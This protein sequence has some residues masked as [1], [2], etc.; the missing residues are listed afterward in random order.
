MARKLK[1]IQDSV[2][3]A[4]TTTFSFRN[5]TRSIKPHPALGPASILM[6]RQTNS[7]SI[8]SQL[9]PGVVGTEKVST[10]DVI[11]DTDNIAKSLIGVNGT[12]ID[13]CAI[14]VTN[15][16]ISREPEASCARK[17]SNS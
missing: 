15:V 1:G 2:S 3:V 13:N 7:H 14:G 4:S 12:L 8:Q 9:N 6:D 16:Q 17:R 11:L 5:S 10:S